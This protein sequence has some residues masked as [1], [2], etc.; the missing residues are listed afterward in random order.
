MHSSPQSLTLYILPQESVNRVVLTK[1]LHATHRFSPRKK[2]KRLTSRKT[3]IK[4]WVYHLL[5][6]IRPLS[7]QLQTTSS[8]K[9]CLLLWER[10]E[11]KKNNFLL[12]QSCFF[13]ILTNFVW[14]YFQPTNKRSLKPL[15]WSMCFILDHKGDPQV[16]VVNSLHSAFHQNATKP[17]V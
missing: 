9:L 11:K 12:N 15:T 8:H 7:L 2:M 17:L 13:D 4:L 3:S 1:Q 14:K 16:S 6:L 5:I 10:K